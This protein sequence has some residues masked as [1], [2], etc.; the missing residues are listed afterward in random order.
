[1]TL[2]QAARLALR[3]LTRKRQHDPGS[4]CE[5]CGSCDWCYARKEAVK[6]L[7]EA[8]S[9]SSVRDADLEKKP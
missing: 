5:P 8:L 9:A 3:K 6:L 1:M 4:T 2:R 7:R